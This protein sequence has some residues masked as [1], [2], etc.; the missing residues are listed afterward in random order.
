MG[1]RF[2]PEFGCHSGVDVE[3]SIMPS[4]GSLKIC[5]NRLFVGGSDVGRPL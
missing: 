2:S 4:T 5:G 3:I 1:T